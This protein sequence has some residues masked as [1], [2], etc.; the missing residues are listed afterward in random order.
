MWLGGR[1]THSLVGHNSNISVTSCDASVCIGVLYASLCIAQVSLLSY[2]N[3][4]IYN[5]IHSC[6]FLLMG[7]VKGVLDSCYI[8]VETVHCSEVR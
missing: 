7:L 8:N 6:V 5:V 3:H 2:L 1:S 4:I